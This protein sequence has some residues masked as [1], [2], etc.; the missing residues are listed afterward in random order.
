MSAAAAAGG[1]G[2]SRSARPWTPDEV[3]AFV[4]SVEHELE[5]VRKEVLVPGRPRRIAGECYGRQAPALAKVSAIVPK[6]E[7]FIGGPALSCYV[8]T[9]FGCT[10]GSWIAE[11]GIVLEGAP[12]MKP[13]TR[14]KVTILEQ[15]RERVVAEVVE[16][17]NVEVDSHGVLRRNE[18]D[19]PEGGS[20]EYSDAELATFKQ[21]S[22][23]TLTL[24]ADGIW[25]ISDRKPTWRWECRPR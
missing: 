21:Y 6:L 3:R 12:D 22:R 23:Y 7:R 25:R 16:A 13:F 24:G 15:S 11:A 17:D 1:S 4:L 18:D 2:V 19:V 20:R 5:Q 14:S 9:Y 8:A 10:V